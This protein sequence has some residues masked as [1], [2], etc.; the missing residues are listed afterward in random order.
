MW[1]SFSRC[2]LDLEK[3]KVG[4]SSPLPCH[5]DI[6]NHYLINVF[7][8]FNENITLASRKKGTLVPISLTFF[9]LFFFSHEQERAL[10]FS[11]EQERGIEENWRKRDKENESVPPRKISKGVI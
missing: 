9:H 1:F 2:Y 8:L 3:Y 10:F 6:F 11:H 5:V 7:F 4:N